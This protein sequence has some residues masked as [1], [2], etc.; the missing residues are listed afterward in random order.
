M[1]IG[2]LI[3]ALA[4]GAMV[5]M[6]VQAGEH[7]QAGAKQAGVKQVSSACAASSASCAAAKA[8]GK[9]CATTTMASACNPAGCD[10]T[11]GGN[12]CQTSMTYVVKVNGESKATFNRQEAQSW[13]SAAGT[14]IEFVVAGKTFASEDEAKMGLFTALHERVQSMLTVMCV[15]EQGEAVACKASEAKMTKDGKKMTYRVAN[16]DFTSRE[17]A[18]GYLAKVNARLASLK[19]VDD[20]GKPIDGCAVEYSKASHCK[21]IQVGDKKFENPMEANITFAQERLR[22]LLTTEA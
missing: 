18:D 10:F 2:K 14:P 7:C 13:A 6:S 17:A 15:N 1:K 22:V 5:G 16:H 8:A 11:K 20:Q 3:A 19:M 21:S 4:L 9:S 12:C